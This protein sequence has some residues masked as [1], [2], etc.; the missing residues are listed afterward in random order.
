VVQPQGAGLCGTATDRQEQRHGDAELL[1]EQSRHCLG[2]AEPTGT[3]GPVRPPTR[4]I[5]RSH[6]QWLE[7][8][9][10]QL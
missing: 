5:G 1:L 6:E 7:A 10:L 3:D 4:L 9:D 8:I 2:I